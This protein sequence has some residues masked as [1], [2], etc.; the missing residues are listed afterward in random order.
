MSTLYA[1]SDT[2]GVLYNT[3]IKKS[4]KREKKQLNIFQAR[5]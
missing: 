1:R 5:K 2:V 3:L 4:K